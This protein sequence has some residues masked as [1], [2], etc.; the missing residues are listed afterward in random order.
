MCDTRLVDPP[1]PLRALSLLTATLQR[2]PLASFTIP[3][4]P[5]TV[6][7]AFRKRGNGAGLFKTAKAVSWD[8]LATLTIRNAYRKQ[9][10]IAGRVYL[11][12]AL[13]VKDKRRWDIDNRLKTLEDAI[14]HAGVWL[15]DEQVDGLT[16]HREVDGTLTES[17]CRV[18]VWETQPARSEVK[19]ARKKR[20]TAVRP[21][22]EAVTV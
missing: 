13:Y 6:N 20:A 14:T 16:L 1:E 3:G 7:H 18:W 5:P 10:P 22:R 12:V 4:L 2:Q 19:L 21:R 8:E 11:L 9:S 15:D 17:F